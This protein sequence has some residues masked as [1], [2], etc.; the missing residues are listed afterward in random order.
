MRCVGE[1]STTRSTSWWK[2]IIWALL[3]ALNALK[4]W[5]KITTLNHSGKSHHLL[6]SYESQ[7]SIWVFG[8]EQHCALRGVSRCVTC[9]VY[10]LLRQL[11]RY[12]YKPGKTSRDAWSFYLMSVASF[13]AIRGKQHAQKQCA[14]VF[15]EVYFFLILP[16]TNWTWQLRNCET[17]RNVKMT[18]GTQGKRLP[19]GSLV[20]GL[21]R[22]ARTL[23]KHF[24]YITHF[25]FILNLHDSHSLP[26]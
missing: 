15:H 14:I 17:M 23:R 3:E 13:P 18:T 19:L 4:W 8:V 7:P 22:T 21:V 5:Q 25:Y 2:K 9:A 11:W 16:Q 1:V 12:S 24:N 6:L 10:C 26:A 20:D